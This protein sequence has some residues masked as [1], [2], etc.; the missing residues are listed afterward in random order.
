MIPEQL[1][2][3]YKTTLV[4]MSNSNTSLNSKDEHTNTTQGLPGR[5]LLDKFVLCSFVKRKP[6]QPNKRS[7]T[8]ST[9]TVGTSTIVAQNQ[10]HNS[11]NETDNSI[12]NIQPDTEKDN[13]SSQLLQF[14]ALFEFDVPVSVDRQ[15][16][17]ALKNQ[18][19]LITSANRVTPE[20]HCLNLGD[21]SNIPVIF[22]NV[23]LYNATSLYQALLKMWWLKLTCIQKV[24][25]YDSLQQMLIKEYSLY[26]EVMHY[27]DRYLYDVAVGNQ[28]SIS[29][30]DFRRI[31]ILPNAR[32]YDFN[33]MQQEFQIIS[34][35]LS[36]QNSP[37]LTLMCMS[38]E[39]SQDLSNQ[40]EQEKKTYLAQNTRKS[41]I[42]V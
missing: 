16:A 17:S 39:E 34:T 7:K 5:H 40:L 18:Y 21:L 30:S 1:A 24:P 13:G 26:G 6:R 33:L 2:Q 42:Q 4:K 14:P 32:T 41:S 20:V 12:S 38:E 28:T 25:T 29:L 37:A 27:V 15:A 23:N 11:R 36:G 22:W 19:V 9:V 3:P 8:N 10:R 35:T 31:C